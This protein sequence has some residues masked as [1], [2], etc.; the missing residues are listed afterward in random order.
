MTCSPAGIN[1]TLYFPIITLGGLI[2]ALFVAEGPHRTRTPRF[3]WKYVG[4]ILRDR[5]IALANLARAE[6]IL[7]PGL[8]FADIN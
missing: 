5:D 7:A 1:R 6:G 2:A 3:S 4:E 8:S